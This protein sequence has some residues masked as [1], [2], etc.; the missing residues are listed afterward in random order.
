M[1]RRIT[2]VLCVMMAMV[3]CVGCFGKAAKAEDHG[4]VFGTLTYSS[5]ISGSPVGDSFYYSDEWLLG[6]PGEQNDQLALISAQLAAASDE[7]EA[8]AFLEKIGFSNIERNRFDSADS[9]DCAYVTGTKSITTDAGSRSVR[10]VVFQGHSY[11]EKGWLQ[12]VTVNPEKGVS[13]E[14]AAYAAA[15]QIF[16]EDY[17]RM[18]QEDNTILWLCGLSRGGAV[19][20]VASAYLL[21]REDAPELV[22][23]TFEAPATTQRKEAHGEIYRYIFNY[24]SDNDPVTMIPMWGMTRFGTEILINT[25]MPSELKSVLMKMNSDAVEYMEQGDISALDGDVRAFVTS[26]LEKLMLLIPDRQSYSAINMLSLQE[27]G[28]IEYSIQDSLKAVIRLLYNDNKPDRDSLQDLLDWIPDAAWAYLAEAWVAENNP[29]NSE[30]LLQEAAQKRWNVAGVCMDIMPEEAREII[31]RE[32]L[33][34]LLRMIS[35]LLVDHSLMTEGWKL[36]E[37]ES[38]EE[39]GFVN[40]AT[41]IAAG[42]NSSLLILSHQPDVILARMKRL[43]P[44]PAFVE[45][46]L[47]LSDPKAGDSAEKT[48]DE[49]RSQMDSSP[50]SWLWIEKASWLS[51]G[52]DILA[53]QRVHYLGVTLAA[54]GHLIPDDFRFTVNGAEPIAQEIRYENGI[55]L[56]DGVWL[57]RLG[58]PAPASVRFD[59]TGHGSAPEPCTVESGTMLRY[60]S[61]QLPDPGIIRDEQGTWEFSEWTYE[62]GTDWKDAVAVED[63]TLHAS[64]IRIIDDIALTFTVPR[65][66]DSGEEVLRFV[67]LPDGLPLEWDGVYLYNDDSWEDV[68]EIKEDETYILRGSIK[69]VGENSC[70]LTETTEDGD[71]FYAGILTVNGQKPDSFELYSNTDNGV[72]EWEISFVYSFRLEEP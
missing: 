18:P 25:E 23:F 15:A 34:A 71:A 46:N 67:S 2:L 16:L 54:V 14:H 58:D 51:S 69:N 11:G 19:A 20:N 61:M 52:D 5:A 40:Y 39:T 72:T 42:G 22:C 43:V 55:A 59:M 12:N 17:D 60:A 1:K 70:F 9:M 29:E 57:F 63:I 36:P 8:S 65:R 56:I 3:F 31:H 6:V 68:E 49:I 47:K 45:Y 27:T 41:L 30:E 37:R 32:D 10:V 62:D 53:D 24:L 64:W 4:I 38:L 33:Y 21:E 13:A 48:P 66:G 7:T 50:G 26:I 35:P 44:A 28:V